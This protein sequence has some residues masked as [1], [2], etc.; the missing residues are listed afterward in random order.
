V[1]IRRDD[2]Y[3]M[4]AGSILD[5]DGQPLGGATVD[6]E[7]L[8]TTSMPDGTFEVNIPIERQKPYPHVRISKQGF[9]TEEFTQQS[10]GKD[11]TVVMIKN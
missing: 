4:L 2:T 5:E 9:Q 1:N 3:G 7:G 11:W 6:V 8:M 10:V